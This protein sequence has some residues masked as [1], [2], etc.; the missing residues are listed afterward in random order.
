MTVMD[1][2]TTPPADSAPV[3]PKRSNHAGGSVFGAL[4]RHPIRVV[5]SVL[6][7]TALLVIPFLTM[8]PTESASTEPG[9]AVFDAR[10]R[11]DE[12]FV[13]TVRPVLLIAEHDSGDLLRAA[14][15]RELA[16]AESAL[17]SRPDL[18]GAL[19][20]FYDVETDRDIDGVSSVVD[21]IDRELV[22]M[23]SSLDEATDD[24]VAEAAATLIDRFGERSDVLGISAQAAQDSNGRWIVPAVTVVVLTDDTVL[25]F[26]NNAVNFGGGTEVEAFDRGVQQI[27]RDVTPNFQVNAVAIDVNLTSEEQGAVAGPFIGF[28]I[29]AVLLI[30][31]L[32]FRSYWI[33]AIVG[34]ALMLLIIWL[35]GISNLIG[36]KDDLVLSLIVPIA[37]VSFGVDFAF[38]S[39]GRY[40]EERAEGRTA[41]TA[42]VTG[43]SAVSAAL[44]LALV[45]DSV[46]FLSNVT[47]GIESIVQFGVGAAIALAAAYLLLGVVAPLVVSEVEA[48]V[49]APTPT[50]R[51]VVLR[52]L[53]AFGAASL[54]M[55]SVL[56]LVFLL[57]W[58]GVVFAVV[59]VLSTVAIPMWL[60]SRSGGERVG[61]V[62]VAAGEHRVAD[63]I[64]TAVA[65]VTSARRVV[66]PLVALATVGA[67]TLAVQVPA[68]FDVEDFF[69]ADTDF[70]VSLDQLDIHV[71]D[72][73]GEIA[74]VYIEGD[75]T[76]PDRL[77]KLRIAAD[78]IRE[79]DSR[80][81]ALD[82]D[83]LIAID[84][85][86][87][88]VLDD[89]FESPVMAGLVADR[90]GRP[91]ADVDGDRIPD[92]RDQVEAVL[93]IA[94]TIGIPL[95][96]ERL[97][98]TPNDVSVRVDLEGTAATRFEVE[99]TDTRSQESVLAVQDSLEPIVTELSRQ[100]GATF[101][102][103][104]GGP[105]VRAESLQA[106]N[107]ALGLSLPIAVVLCLLVA[108]VFLRS[109]RYG[110][111]SVIPILV[112]VAWLYAFMEVAGYAINL[113]TATI[114]AVSIGIGIDFAIHFITRYREELMRSGTSDEAVRA[115]AAG[116][117]TA[118]VASAFSSAIGFGILAL[119]PMPLFAS[120]G[121][122]TAIMIVMA[123]TATLLVL[124]SV[125][126]AITSDT[127]LE[128]STLV[129]EAPISH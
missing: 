98:M 47:A 82:G 72:R 40:R 126:V 48:R 88:Q 129:R 86:V 23:G 124:P 27:V 13:S 25:G 94:S 65:R 100:L 35:K 29:L 67:A 74:S 52:V 32:T 107:R 21:L 50:R 11:I 31:G 9:G 118:L 53:A 69:A 81:L 96:V 8:A 4:G 105:I 54:V 87:L 102:E 103:T 71:G 95:D 93:S 19:F 22:A 18:D 60:R 113:V 64:S 56:L 16:A 125:L 45:S 92:D 78:E 34:S 1:A 10:D 76:D 83:S 30:V 63:R 14:P 49:P 61:D 127:R 109:F 79:L 85:G 80:L 97:L 58:L 57:P 46:A 90:T 2:P 106:T 33:T 44:V 20:S 17:R 89:A 12:R 51:S 28:T 15:L 7:V 128:E 108:S 68:E 122:L 62:S 6:A 120:Y 38:H 39:I 59:T 112:V 110:L 70:V 115:T 111:A 114:A 24:G 75:L 101:V 66:L 84:T 41:R 37:M 91:L 77:G 119:A 3:P 5:A 121:L 55:T 99:L 43:M 104:T 42:Y 26:G 36:L 117:G 123:L 73:G 116:T